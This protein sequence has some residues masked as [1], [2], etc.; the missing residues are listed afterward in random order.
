MDKQKLTKELLGMVEA[1][2]NADL[3]R[4]P[5][6]RGEEIRAFYNRESDAILKHQ[7]AQRKGW[8][9][10]INSFRFVEH[11]SPAEQ[12]M[13]L[14]IKCSQTFL[15]PEVP[16]LKYFID[17]GH[18]HLRVGLEVDGKDFHDQQLDMARDL[19]LW[20]CGW[21]IFRI[22][23]RE[24]LSDLNR[25]PEEDDDFWH[26]NNLDQIQDFL[27]STGEGLL[28]CLEWRFFG[29]PMP[30]HDSQR[31]R[32]FLSDIVDSTLKARNQLQLL[33]VA[34]YESGL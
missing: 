29:Q 14:A 23:A 16:V 34:Q 3:S 30:F 12:E 19:E 18:L 15:F 33:A 5:S 10:D 13:W 9:I 7:R 2:E 11:M 22:P 32:A 20:Q 31:E 4:R 26:P 1:Y 27:T 28:R 6:W 17:F 25:A 21:V 8:G 24:V